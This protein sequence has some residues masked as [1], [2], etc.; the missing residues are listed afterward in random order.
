MSFPVTSP[1]KIGC[2]SALAAATLVASSATCAADPG[3]D[4]PGP[5]PIPAAPAE[6]LGPPPPPPPSQ[7]GNPLAIAGTEQ[8]PGGIPANLSI[9]G[10]TALIGQNSA[11]AAPGN[12]GPITNP[13][14]NALNNQYLLPQN[15]RPA[16]P[17][18]GEI[19]EIAPG[20]ENADIA[21]GDYLRRLWHQYQG[22]QLK[23]GLLG[24]RPK[25]E[26]NQPIPNTAPPPGTRIP[27]LGDDSQGPA[28]EQWHWSPPEPP[29]SPA[30]PPPTA[31]TP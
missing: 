7:I 26:L 29:E 23:G 13:G 27:G 4:Q 15:L 5:P 22:G 28:P 1:I 11:P 2:A 25:E 24:R 6:P 14:T 19:Y 8:G 30:K 31:T 18:K 3:V 16:E 12:S 20:E 17:G 10:D 21:G 9:V